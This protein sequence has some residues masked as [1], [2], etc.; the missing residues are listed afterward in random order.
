MGLRGATVTAYD[1]NPDLALVVE[2]TSAGDVSPLEKRQAPTSLGQG[3][4]ISFMD[5][6]I[7]VNPALVDELVTTANE[8]GLAYQF[9]QT[10]GGGTEAGV[11]NQARTGVPTAVI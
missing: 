6:S 7:I 4:A 8:A 11:I 3:P 9:R 1:L 10:T 2:T 5:Q